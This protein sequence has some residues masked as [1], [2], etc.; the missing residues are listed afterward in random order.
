MTLFTVAGARAPL[1]C[2]DSGMERSAMARYIPILRWKRGERVGI[3]NLTAKQR[4]NVYPLFV[5]G[6]SPFVGKEPKN[7]PPV[8]AGDA[9][10]S[11][12]KESWGANWCHIDASAAPHAGGGPHP[13]VAIAKSAA[14]HG[15]HF[16]PATRLGATSN[17]Q[18]AVKA[19]SGSAG[20]ALRVTLEEMTSASTWSSSWDHAFKD[21][22]L[23]V[24]F[25]ETTS[26]VHGLGASLVH[27]FETLHAAGRWRTVTVAGT[28]MPDN[29]TG[30]AK[31]LHTIPRLE[32]AIWKKLVAASLPYQV[33]YGDYATVPLHPPPATIK[34]GYPINARYTLET[35]FLICRG[36]GTTGKGG[37]DMDV[38]L[39]Q[40]AK[41]IVA[42]SRRGA[43]AD[44][45]ADS[46]IDQIAK[47]VQESGNLESWVQIGVNRHIAK[48]RATIK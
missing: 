28:S 27:A 12:L 37:V 14:A 3:K 5:L 35:E 25:A 41:S 21:T 29:F 48:V 9:F 19:V 33:D 32:Q 20:V 38:Q 34:W 1:R 26:T 13:L 4:E 15:L 44:C 40:H 16:V 30:L 10:V 24:D 45:W 18:A 22:D 23:I 36:V 11:D 17:Y 7:K 42:Y 46:R 43:I 2:P 47:G 8:S 39:L 31:G 6:E